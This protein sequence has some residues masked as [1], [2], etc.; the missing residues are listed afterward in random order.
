MRRP[1]LIGFEESQAVCKAFR[2][3]GYEAYSCDIKKCSGGHP[4]WHL[5][6][7]IMEAMELKDW[8]FIGLHPEC[9]TLTVAGNRTYAYGMPKHEERL[10]QLDWTIALWN[11]A[12]ANSSYTYLENPMGMLNSDRRMPK[13][14]IVQ[15]F[16]FG[17]PFQKTTCIWLNN[18]PHLY[19]NATPNLFDP[20][21]THVDNGEFYEWIDKKTGK[22]KRQP[23]WYAQAK[24]CGGKQLIRDYSETRSKTFPGIANAMAKQWGK[25]ITV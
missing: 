25:L 6:M 18:L 13:P 3:L 12:I 17:D 8:F 5:Q 20:H 10:K 2:T 4:E 1:I 9:T 15:P 7:D 24:G 16:Y 19:H 23:L 14:Q 21:V 22:K 11:K